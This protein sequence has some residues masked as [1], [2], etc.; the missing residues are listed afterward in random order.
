M[1]PA[2]VVWLIMG[3]GLA[4]YVLTGGADFG[5]GFWDLVAS[6]PTE[7]KQRQA[8][9]RT[10]APIWEANHVWLIFVVVCM[11]SAFPRAFAV[12]SVALHIPFTIVLVGIVLRGA[13]F[14]F[15]AYGLGD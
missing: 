10:I 13:A 2:Y 9:A 15:R 5:G 6:G 7:A 1:T 8:I 4:A 14:V 3:A 12:V 11:F